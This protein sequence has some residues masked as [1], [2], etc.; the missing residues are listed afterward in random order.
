[1]LWSKTEKIVRTSYMRVVPE[2]VRPLCRVGGGVSDDEVLDEV[3]VHLARAVVRGGADLI[4]DGDSTGFRF[5]Q[6]NFLI[7]PNLTDI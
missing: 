7:E 4:L 3:L 2:D 5:C 1:M 6:I